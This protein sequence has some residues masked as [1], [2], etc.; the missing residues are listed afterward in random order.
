MNFSSWPAL[1]VVDVEGNGTNPPDLVEVAAL[2]V[3]DGQPDESTAGAWLTKPNR[4]VTPFATRVHGLT[5]QVLEDKPGWEEIKG[6]VHAFLGTA[7]IAAHNAH[8][9][10]RVLSAHL[11]Q[12]QPAGVIDTLRLAKATYPDLAKYDL[13]TLI[14]HV[15]PDL[16]QAP[17][18]RHRATFD[19]YATAQLL[20]AMAGRY[21]S[22]DQLVAVAVPPGLPGAPEPEQEPTLW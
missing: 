10:H 9:D 12:W 1:L 20:I 16:S 3:R 5:N 17:A 7:W 18:Q 22:W 21:E 13:D 15:E 14:E 6:A 4:P 8:V 2:P 11:P 19:T